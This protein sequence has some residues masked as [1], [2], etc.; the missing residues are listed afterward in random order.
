MNLTIPTMLNW[1]NTKCGKFFYK[2]GR[3]IT[4]RGNF[5]TKWGRYYKIGKAFLQSRVAL[6]QIGADNLSEKRNCYYKVGQLYYKVGQVLK[7]GTSIIKNGSTLPCYK[8][9]QVIYYKVV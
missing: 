9:R 3:S 1:F 7:G 5:I 8:V 6:L 2:V 4:N